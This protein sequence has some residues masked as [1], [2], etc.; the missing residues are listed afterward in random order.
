MKSNHDDAL[1]AAW[2]ETL[3]RKSDA[4]AIFDTSGKIARTFAEIETQAGDFARKIDMFDVG[5]VLAIQIGNQPD[6]PAI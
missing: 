1:L 6:W 3:A 5:S 2:K 4:A